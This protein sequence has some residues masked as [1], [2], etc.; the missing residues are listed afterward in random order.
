MEIAL[1]AVIVIL[2]AV[3]AWRLFQQQEPKKQDDQSLLLIQNQ[4]NELTRTLDSKLGESTKA[5]SNSTDKA[6]S[7][8]TESAKLI[9]E[10]TQELAKVGEGQRQVVNIADNLKNLQDILKNPKQRGVLGEFQQPLC[11]YGGIEGD[12]ADAKDGVGG[13]N[14]QDAIN[15]CNRF[16][17]A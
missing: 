12:V 4:I 1:F 5:I 6:L 3:I 15:E 2:L 7:Q 13:L 11:K 10:I 14:A 16:I 9:K 17:S 8:A